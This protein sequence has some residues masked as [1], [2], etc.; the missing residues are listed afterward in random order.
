MEK[1]LKVKLDPT[2]KSNATWL[3]KN[4]KRLI[5]KPAKGFGILVFSFKRT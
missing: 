1:I 3:V 5:I 4:I 2:Q